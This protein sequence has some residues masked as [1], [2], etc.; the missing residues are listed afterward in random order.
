MSAISWADDITLDELDDPA[1]LHTG[2]GSGTACATGGCPV[3]GN[4]VNGFNGNK[5][6][7][8]QQS[9]AAGALHV[10]WLLILAVPN[11]NNPGLFTSASISSVTSINAY[12]G[13]TTAT[14]SATFGGAAQSGWNGSGFAGTMTSGDVYH[15]AFFTNGHLS[16]NGVDASN[17][18]T[19]YHNADLA[20]TGINASSFG[21]YIFAITAPLSAQGLTD[22][23]FADGSL[24]KGTFVVAYGND[25]SHV[26]VNP[27]TEAGLAEHPNTVTPE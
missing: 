6:D 7:I 27:F 4:E 25:G 8:Y 1:T 16:G 12:P 13:G 18:F 26:Y 5:V 3:F 10:P 22:I 2:T 14:G 19:N 20:V 23:T 15:Q 21:I 9:G 11:A 24:P 17:S